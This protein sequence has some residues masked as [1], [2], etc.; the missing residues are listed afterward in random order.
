MSDRR[1][2]L[3]LTAAGALITLAGITMYVLPGPGFTILTIGMSLLVTG[4]V[5]TA[6]HP[7]S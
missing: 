6:G 7:H 5:M 4:L 2:G 3:A 1:I